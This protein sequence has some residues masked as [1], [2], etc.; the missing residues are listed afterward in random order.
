LTCTNVTDGNGQ[1]DINDPITTTDTDGIFGSAGST[2]SLAHTTGTTYQKT[3]LNVQA[4]AALGAHNYTVT[5]T[6][7]K[8]VTGSLATPATFTVT[9]A[10]PTVSGCAFSPGSGDPGSTTNLSCTVADPNGQSDINTVTTVDVSGVFGSAGSTL[11]LTYNAGTGKYET[12]SKTVG[13]KAP[14]PYYYDVTVTDFGGN[15]VQQTNIQF[16]VNNVAPSISGCAFSP[17]SG[18]PGGTTNLSCTVSD[19]NGLGTIS[20][21]RTT[22]TSGVFGPAG[23][24]L[25]LTY[26]AGTGKYETGSKTVQAVTATDY[27]YTVRATDAS[28]AFSEQT[29]VKF[30]VNN[31]APS[32]SGVAFNPGWIDQNGTV[33]TTV[34]ATVTDPNG[35]TDINTVSVNMG[36]VNGVVIT[37]YNDGP[38]G[39]HGDAD[40][41]DNIYTNNAVQGGVTTACGNKQITVTGWDAAGLSSSAQGT[42]SINGAPSV[43]SVNFNPNPIIPDGATPFTITVKID[44]C[45]GYADVTSVQVDLSLINRGTVTLYN[46]GTHGDVTSGDDTFTL[47]GTT[48]PNLWPLGN[49]STPTTATDS[50]GLQGTGSGILIVNSVVPNPPVIN[51]GTSA[52]NQ[53]TLT[54]TTPTKNS[55]G[56]PLTDLAQH[57]FYVSTTSGGPYTLVT[58]G[59][60][61]NTLTGVTL[62]FTD[63][64]PLTSYQTYCYVATS[65]NAGGSEGMYSN[66]KCII[67]IPPGYG[68]DQFCANPSRT[69]YYPPNIPEYVN[70]PLAVAYDPGT[71]HIFVADTD[72]NRI[73]EFDPNAPCSHVATHGSYGSSLGNYKQPSGI[74][75]SP[76]NGYLYVTDAFYRVQAIDTA[77]N[78]VNIWWSVTS[79]YGIAA[80]TAGNIYVTS[81]AGKVYK[82]DG[83]GN[84][85]WPTPVNVAGSRGIGVDASGNIYVASLDR[86]LVVKLDSNGNEVGTIGAPGT[87]YG[88]FTKPISVTIDDTNGYIYVSDIDKDI[89]QVFTMSGTLINTVGIPGG[90]D[91]EMNDPMGGAILPGNRVYFADRLN[92]RITGFT[93]P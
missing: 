34:T 18:D 70:R 61:N 91:G 49:Y 88:Q 11:T 83:N 4:V 55:D 42:L 64:G 16:T 22:D 23:G 41:N 27:Y 7:S 89:V 78:S 62:T 71:G 57:K 69:I 10:P 56:T 85:L 77:G 33:T 93:L 20:T 30:T 53:I 28:S 21:V 67:A 66:E 76:A 74:V 31:V 72:N 12:G 24:T 81:T 39:G 44:D 73:N 82:Y 8:G 90:D 13:A 35:K 47:S 6:D 26:N 2:I 19:G 17:G 75:R 37:M 59:T 1:G 79:P 38:A 15:T 43:V 51:A 14:G 92:Q 36:P 86:K 50:R 60:V 65:L 9:N 46:D 32:V 87:G 29:N 3:G 52:N 5:A 25:T 58:G 68:F 84:P 48:V 45:N 63:V 80:D 40:A 54:Y